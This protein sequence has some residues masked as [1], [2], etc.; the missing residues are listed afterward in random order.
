M[1]DLEVK[2]WSTA[3]H[4]GM[5]IE[6]EV[7]WS[8]TDPTDVYS[9]CTTVVQNPYYMPTYTHTTYIFYRVLYTYIRM[10]HTILYILHYIFYSLS[11]NTCS[12]LRSN[13]S[14]SPSP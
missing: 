3:E 13:P 12:S 7:P 11:T 14:P 2:R 9:G 10:V 4:G 1:H 8:H 5:Y 6:M